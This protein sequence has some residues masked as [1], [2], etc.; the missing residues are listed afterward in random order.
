MTR[1]RIQVL[2]Q[3]YITLF[4]LVAMKLVCLR[5][6]MLFLLSSSQMI[7]ST[8]LGHHAPSS[9]PV[10][11]AYIFHFAPFPPGGGGQKYDLLAGWGQKYDDLLRKSTYIRGKRWKNWGKKEEIFTVLQGKNVIYA[12]RGRPGRGNI[13]YFLQIFTPACV[14]VTSLVGL[15]RGGMQKTGLSQRYLDRGFYPLMQCFEDVLF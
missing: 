7:S 11:G 8:A 4:P 1:T 2:G 3:K 14:T 12:N 10:S 6:W 15:R 5:R 13:S 9:T